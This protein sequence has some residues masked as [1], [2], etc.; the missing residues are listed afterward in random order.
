[1][2]NAA[3][4]LSPERHGE[5]K[6]AAAAAGSRSGSHKVMRFVTPTDWAPTN[7][8]SPN[9]Y[10]PEQEDASGQIEAHQQHSLEIDVAAEEATERSRT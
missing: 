2:L 10:F 3:G 8:P 6:S 5:S 4:A 7:V 9:P 1:M